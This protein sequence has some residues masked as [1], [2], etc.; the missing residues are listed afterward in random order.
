MLL[1]P[2]VGP[3]RS[4]AGGVQQTLSAAYNLFPIAL[5]R[6]L[7]LGRVDLGRDPGAFFLK[8]HRDP[9]VAAERTS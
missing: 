6:G 1:N 4:K 9:R 3:T 8:V 5:Q 7:D 2:V